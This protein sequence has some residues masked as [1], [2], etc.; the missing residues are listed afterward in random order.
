[1]ASQTHTAHCIYM[2][3]V[4]RDAWQ[5][6]FLEADLMTPVSTTLTFADWNQI[7]ELARNGK[8]LGTP[9]AQQLFEC[10]VAMG[11]GGTYLQLTPEQYSKLRSPDKGDGQK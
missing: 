7:R 6:S 4:L 10:A 8:A 3:F 9:Q 5:V 1:M 11:R 2:Q